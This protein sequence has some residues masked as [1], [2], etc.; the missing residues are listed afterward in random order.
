MPSAWNEAKIENVIISDNSISM[1]FKKEGNE[2]EIEITQE[3]GDWEIHFDPSFYQFKSLK[4]NNNE[5]ETVE[6]KVISS[7]G[8]S[9]SLTLTL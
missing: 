3:N 9:I 8:K 2:I 6:N 4:L 1:K 5:I 7:S